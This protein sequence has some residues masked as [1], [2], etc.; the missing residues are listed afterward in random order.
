MRNNAYRMKKFK[1][2]PAKF[3]LFYS[4]FFGLLYL[5]ITPPFQSPDEINHF[6]R[7]YQISEG[8]FVAKKKGD[9]LG[10]DIPVSLKKFVSYYQQMPFNRFDK[11]NIQYLKETAEIKLNPNEKIFVDFP[12][13]AMYSPV[14]Y[15][16]QATAVFVFRL[17]KV[18][19]LFM[20]YI[21]RF[22]SLIFW[23]VVVYFS[24]KI[25]P[26]YKWL[27]V[28]LSVLPMS[29]AIAAS[30]S[31][32]VVTNALSFLLIAYYFKITFSK[33]N[34]TKKD[35]LIISAIVVFL[36]FSKLLYVVLMFLFFIIPYK[37]FSS[38]KFYFL[39]VFLIAFLGFG[40]AFTAK[41]IIDELY[42][43]A[44]EYNV[45]YGKLAT[46]GD[47]ANMEKQIQF[48]KDNKIKTIKIFVKSFFVGF[49]RMT[50]SYIG[51]LGWSDTQLRLLIVI[52]SYIVV[53]F[54]AIFSD[55]GKV[56]FSNLQRFVLIFVF[57]A[58][59][60]L[61]MLS[62]Y[63]TWDAVGADL[64]E[65]FQGRYF[66]P[67]FPLIFMLL[68]NVKFAVK[69]DFLM[70]IVVIFAVFIGFW[71]VFQLVD[72]FFY[73]NKTIKKLEF[74]CSAEHLTQDERFFRVAGNDT[75][76]LGNAYTRTNEMAL[77][78]EY[79]IKL[80]K[81]NPFGF[82]YKFSNIHKG[83][84]FDV[85]V[86]R[87]GKSGFIVF[88]EDVKNGIYYKE[89]KVMDL[90]RNWYCVKAQFVAPKDFIENGLKIYIWYPD[91]DSAY[92]DDFKVIYYKNIDK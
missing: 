63:L 24:I 64:V 41:T 83:D 33:E 86:W 28:V 68:Y 70:K 20:F 31:A 80:S 2:N 88:Q 90:S 60:V 19:P 44:D 87:Y 11:I 32:D 49:D 82:T 74:S 3:F 55:V 58:V 38:L 17:L 67:I 12:N 27:F 9:R 6:Y 75:I 18:K 45:M 25:I 61:I 23:I 4:L 39:S 91:S 47:N 57:G 59:F 66:I 26:V 16:P 43:P 48:I 34:F 8:V 73:F 22:F 5:L 42:I 79:S 36:G 76:T 65:P 50:K 53:F 69:D 56:G 81:K 52:I 72:R 92:F 51:R 71:T 30:L 29:V 89:R 62:Q 77:S 14:S 35:L 78:G 85:S 7:A 37:K 15:I 54:V 46:I 40:S 21:A 13:T 1:L 84:R 10:G